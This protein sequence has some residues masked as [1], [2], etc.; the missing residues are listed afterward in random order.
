[1][2]PRLRTQASSPA[3]STPSAVVTM[4]SDRAIPTMAETMALRSLMAPAPETKDRSIFSFDTGK[5]VM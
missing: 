2:Q 5:R 1:M 4:L 3:F